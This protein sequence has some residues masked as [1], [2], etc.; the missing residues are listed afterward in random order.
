M[1]VSVLSLNMMHGRRTIPPLIPVGMSKEKI[2]RN[3]EAIAQLLRKYD[4]DIVSLQEVDRRSR[5]SGY[6]DQVDWLKRHAGYSHASFGEHTKGL[7]TSYGT[8]ILS[9]FPI[10]RASSH[11]FPL[12]FPTPRKGFTTCLVSF[13]SGQQIAFASVHATVLNILEINTRK[14]QMQQLATR[15]KEID[16]PFIISGD[17]N[18]HFKHPTDRSLSHLLELLDA[19]AHD[20][21]NNTLLTHPST[22]NRLDWIFPSKHFRLISYETI[23]SRVSDHLPLYGVFELPDSSSSHTPR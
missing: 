10:H 12:T 15:V 13:P 7:H 18:T 9:K 23:D 16:S 11:R 4:P 19:Y 6:I 20:A 8:A 2:E 22:R 3:L 21:E 14:K 5:F 17:F 1:K